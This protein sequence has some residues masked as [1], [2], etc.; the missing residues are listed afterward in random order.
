MA[1]RESQNVSSHQISDRV[2]A[3][4]S[5]LRFEAPP[6]NPDSNAS[7]RGAARGSA[8]Q[9]LDP[10]AFRRRL[11]DVGREDSKRLLARRML[12]RHADPFASAA[13][14]L[15]RASSACFAY[16]N[17]SPRAMLGPWCRR[18]PGRDAS[19]PIDAVRHD[20]TRS[21]HLA[22]RRWRAG[23]RGHVRLPDS[24]MARL[25]P[26]SVARATHRIIAILWSCCAS[27]A[28]RT[29]RTI[30][31]SRPRPKLDGHPSLRNRPLKMRRLTHAHTANRAQ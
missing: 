15:T 16:R 24:C 22:G 10:G 6:M 7:S 20:A 23:G 21:S 18:K 26:G 28:Y 5:R 17:T 11:L 13:S 9:S 19:H 12:V 27:T 29:P 25:A 1:S 4:R 3:G 31:R 8:S 14:K 2:V 30:A